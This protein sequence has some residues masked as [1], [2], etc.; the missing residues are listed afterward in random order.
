MFIWERNTFDDTK[1]YFE[2][3]EKCFLKTIYRFL[4]IKTIP[5]APSSGKTLTWLFDTGRLTGRLK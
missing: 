5:L 2:E 4:E 3:S 1:Q